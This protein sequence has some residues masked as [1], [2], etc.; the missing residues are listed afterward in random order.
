MDPLRRSVRL[1]LP[2][3]ILL[4]GGGVMLWLVKST[5]APDLHTTI[6]HLP[7]VAV[8]TV[9][10]RTVSVPVVGYGTVRPKNQVQIVPQVSG[11]LVFSHS[12]LAEGEVI[13]KGE[14]LFELDPSIYQARVQQ[15]EAEVRALHAILA[16]RGQEITNLDARIIIADK[17]LAL[18]EQDY[19]TSKQLLEQE[20]V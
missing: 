9:V 7:T 13:A 5:P 11:E 4:C 14:L 12:D 3:V 2:P 19:S 10:P 15:A 8:Q 16:R 18:D 17:M 1:A 6:S 20:S